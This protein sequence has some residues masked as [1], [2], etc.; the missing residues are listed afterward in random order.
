MTDD[1]EHVGVG[2]H[3]ARVGHADFRLGLVVLGHQHQ[4]IAKIFECLGRFLDREL[5]AEF[6]MLAERGLF[7]GK[8]RLHGDLDL[9]L[10]RPRGRRRR[11]NQSE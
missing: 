10:L 2:N 6:D 3:V 1:D 8:R 5:R 4:V 7:A 11:H 9:A